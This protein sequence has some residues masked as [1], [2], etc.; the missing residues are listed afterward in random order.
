MGE[1]RF[2]VNAFPRSQVAGFVDGGGEGFRR[3][4][5]GHWRGQARI[6][7]STADRARRAGPITS[8]ANV[9]DR[10]KSMW[11]PSERA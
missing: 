5:V 2:V 11:E 9:S 8:V 10:S 1:G 3:L 6:Q 7:P 4:W